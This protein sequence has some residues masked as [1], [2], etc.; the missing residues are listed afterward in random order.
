[1]TIPASLR[2][3]CLITAVAALAAL[4]FGAQAYTYPSKPVRL[5]VPFPPGGPTDVLARIVA[6]AASLVGRP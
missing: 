2:R 5:M 1:M 6:R 3:R 4:S